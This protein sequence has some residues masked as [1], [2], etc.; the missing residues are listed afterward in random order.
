MSLHFQESLC[1]QDSFPLTVQPCVMPK[2]CET[3]EWSPWSPCSKTC[4]SGRLSP[5][6]RSRSRNVKHIAIGGGQECPELL[7]IETCI[8]EG[9]LL[10]PCP[11]EKKTSVHAWCHRLLSSEVNT[12]LIAA[13][14]SSKQINPNRY[15]WRTSAWK[16]CQVSLLLEQQDPRWHESGPVC[17]GGIQT[18]EVYCAQSLPAAITSR[19]K[20]VSRPV[21]SPLCLGPAP[22]A[23]QLCNVPCSTACIVSSWS[24]WGPC[25]HENCHDPQGKKGFRMRQRHVLM[26]STGPTGHCPHLVESMPCEDP[27]CYRWLA[28]EGICIP[29]HGKCGLG[30]R[31]LKAVCQNE[32]GEEVS[33]SLC[34]VPPPPERMACDIP[35]RMDCVVSEWTVWSSCSQSCSNKNA[36]GKQTRSR[37]LLAL[38]GEGGK[39]CP[40]NQELQEYRLCNDHSCTHLYWETSAWGPCSENTLVTAF[41]VTIGW[42][43]EATC[44]VGIQTRR[45]FCIKSH[46]GQVMTKRCP[47][48]TRPETVRPCF[49]PCKK[50]C[51]VTAFSEWTPC[52]RLCQSVPLRQVGPALPQTQWAKGSWQLSVT[53]SCA[54]SLLA[55]TT[56][57][58]CYKEG[59]LHMQFNTCAIHVLTLPQGNTTIKQSRYRIIIQE[60]ANGGQGCPDTLF[61]ERECEDISLCP[62]YRTEAILPVSKID[63][64]TNL[65]KVE[66]TEMEPLYLGSRV[67][68]AGEVRRQRGMW[69]GAADKS[70]LP[71]TH[72]PPLLV[73]MAEVSGNAQDPERSYQPLLLPSPWQTTITRLF[74]QIRYGKLVSRRRL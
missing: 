54:L 73:S 58:L 10:Q 59:T 25:V 53:S 29:D 66:T 2:D 36:D 27:M 48:S 40:S 42:N 16:E 68:Q 1:M 31:I 30:H 24:S 35:C 21:E 67:C 15:S 63:T 41:N 55:T 51:L 39:P 57:V 33:G 12:F 7:E 72:Y 64:F 62:T 37:S 5:G 71:T 69:E 26:E 6:V 44:G 74:L 60:A 47:E 28:S 49:L 38:A 45:V 43:G 70:P 14:S 23:S 9:E 46:V 52:P 61:E 8:A 17:G 4:R 18:R 3:S 13:S 11:S 19:S 22:S 65:R 32:R 20:E 56:N 50:D 34:P